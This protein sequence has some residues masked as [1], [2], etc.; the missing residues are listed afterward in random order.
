[1]HEIMR[2]VHIWEIDSD[3]RG[4]NYYEANE[5]GPENEVIDHDIDEW[6]DLNEV[7]SLFPN[8]KITVHYA[9]GCAVVRYAL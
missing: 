8:A 6:L 7:I 1:M 5:M 3:G 4:P 2:H 9:D